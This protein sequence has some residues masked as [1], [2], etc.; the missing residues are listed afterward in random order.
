MDPLNNTELLEALFPEVITG[1]E[2]QPEEL[3]TSPFTNSPLG[4]NWDE[5]EKNNETVL[6]K[7]I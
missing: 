4:E 5:R 1:N 3:Y 2:L 7:N 6:I